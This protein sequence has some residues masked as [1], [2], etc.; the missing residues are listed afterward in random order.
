MEALM[1]RKNGKTLALALCFAALIYSC[2]SQNSSVGLNLGYRPGIYEG[3]GQAYRGP[4]HVRVQITPSGIEDIEITDHREGFFPGL[5]AME[6]LLDLVL[7]EGNTD[8]DAVSGATVSSRGFLDAVNDA[9]DKA[10]LA[11]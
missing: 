9:L 8:L 11:Q 5:A 10:R 2:L 4:V 3:S 1:K 6:E 7:I